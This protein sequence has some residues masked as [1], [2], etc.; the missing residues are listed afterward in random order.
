[1]T[2][3]QYRALGKRYERLE[4]HVEVME[5]RKESAMASLQKK[6]NRAEHALQGKWEQKIAGVEKQLKK[7]EGQ[8]DRYEKS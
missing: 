6:H 5:A 2:D 4:K 8:I 7:V 3:T 1:M